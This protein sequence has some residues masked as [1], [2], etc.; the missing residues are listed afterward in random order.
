[1]NESTQHWWNVTNRQ[2]EQY[3]EKNLSHWKFVHD[4]SNTDWPGIEPN[5][6][7]SDR[8]ASGMILIRK[9]Q[10]SSSKTC[11]SATL[12]QKPHELAWD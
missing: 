11:P 4:K 1:M 5:P 3:L 12:P 6:P 7:D 10:S 8:P 9:N 2:K